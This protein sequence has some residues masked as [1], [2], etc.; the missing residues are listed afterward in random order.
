MHRSSPPGVAGKM[1]PDV[2]ECRTPTWL[3]A[4]LVGAPSSLILLVMLGVVNFPGAGSSSFFQ[5]PDMF[6]S[7]TPTGGD[8]GAH[9]LLPRILEDSVL[10]S[11]RVLGW[12]NAWFAG[13]P[14]L[15]LYFPLPMLS[16]VLVDL[17]LPYGIAFKV[18]VAA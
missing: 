9:V 10:P 4:V 17:L 2:S 15:Y 5:F 8:L 13:F 16:I 18:V 1:K 7:T 6:R 12:S 14:V 3:I 11:G